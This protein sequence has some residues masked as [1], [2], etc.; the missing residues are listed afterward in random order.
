MKLEFVL[1]HL[2][3]GRLS[4][5]ESWNLTHNYFVTSA[6][7]QNFNFSRREEVM[8]HLKSSETIPDLLEKIGTDGKVDGCP[9]LF[10]QMANLC[11][12]RGA[13]Q[14]ARN[15]QNL[16]LDWLQLQTFAMDSTPWVSYQTLV[17]LAMVEGYELEAIKYG[18]LAINS[19]FCVTANFLTASVLLRLNR[20]D[21]AVQML[22]KNPH[23]VLRQDGPYCLPDQTCADIS[24]LMGALLTK[25]FTHPGLGDENRRLLMDAY[26][27]EPD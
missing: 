7:Y 6:F 25:L 8:A 16:V 20:I 14:E 13:W 18:E 27:I 3:E 11:R 10:L 12:E 21:E 22:T 15:L 4:H 2:G 5:F 24:E 23:G 19:K 9:V 26:N 1:A 17:A